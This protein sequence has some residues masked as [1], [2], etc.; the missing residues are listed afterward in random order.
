MLFSF[1]CTRHDAV[2]PLAEAWR[3]PKIGK[4]SGLRPAR[5]IELII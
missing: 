2:K 1:L 4:E 3:Q 5:G